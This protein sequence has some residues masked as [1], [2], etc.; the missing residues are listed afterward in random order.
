MDSEADS[1]A[2][3]DTADCDCGEEEYYSR[4]RRAV[5]EAVRSFEPGA[6]SSANMAEDRGRLVAAWA[7]FKRSWDAKRSDVDKDCAPGGPPSPRNLR[8]SRASA[9]VDAASTSGSCYPRPRNTDAGETELEG[10]DETGSISSAG[11][12]NVPACHPSNPRKVVSLL[13]RRKKRSPSGKDEIGAT[14]SLRRSQKHPTQNSNTD[15]GQR[16]S[17][18]SQFRRVRSHLEPPVSGTSYRDEGAK[19]LNYAGEVDDALFERLRDFT[20]HMARYDGGRSS[21]GVSDASSGPKTIP[22]SHVGDAMISD[23]GAAGI[24][25]EGGGGDKS[26]DILGEICLEDFADA[27]SEDFDFLDDVNTEGASSPRQG[28][29]RGIRM[30]SEKLTWIGNEAEFNAFF[31]DVGLDD[32]LLGG[33]A[34]PQPSAAVFEIGPDVLLDW[35]EGIADHN[36]SCRDQANTL[37]EPSIDIRSLAVDFCRR[38]R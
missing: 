19:Y 30:D 13:L 7:A 28:G 3:A 18:P 1:V 5:S 8:T 10:R 12:W 17:E 9:S 38:G 25:T 36:K 14:G 11:F 31:A 15:R 22:A 37:T 6:E 2:L 24:G 16:E 34:P 35:E 27:S 23:H 21:A 20:R 26:G 4:R 29:N 33:D 32:F